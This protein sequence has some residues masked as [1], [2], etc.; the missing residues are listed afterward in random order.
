MQFVN[1][2]R[3]ITQDG[4]NLKI[5]KLPNVCPPCRQCFSLPVLSSFINSA[6]NRLRK[7]IY[8]WQYDIYLG[9]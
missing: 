9:F 7:A 6:L 5:Y 2:L 4:L 8:Q 3:D 1:C